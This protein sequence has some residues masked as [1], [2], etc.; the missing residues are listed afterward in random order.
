MTRKEAINII[1]S[2]TVYT[3]E[4][5]EALETLIP[6]LNDSEESEEERVR[7]DIVGLIK[8]ALNDGSAVSPGSHT[9]KEEA[10]AY[11]EKQKEQPQE[12]L[13]YRMN[14]LM[15]EYIEEGKDEAE[16]EHRLKCYQLFWDALEDANFFEQKEQKPAEWSEEDDLTIADL[17]NYFEGDSLD[18]ST[19]EMVQRI[20]SLRSSWK[21][22][23]EELVALKRA[24]EILRD[25]GHGELSKTV[26]MIEGKLANLAVLNKSIWKPS[27]EQIKEY[28]Y[29]YR[30]FIESGLAS[31]TSKAVT[32]LGE[33]LEQLKKLM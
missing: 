19:E 32:V 10:L 4:E 24:G 1:K 7:K 33:L 22:S 6:E 3:P 12:N 9:T 17:I 18:C 21:P 5:M 30:N 2:A 20:K 28:S 14:G 26:F 15:Q 8:F 23:E 27:E 31:P 29:W 25:Y 11:L 16:K 13:V